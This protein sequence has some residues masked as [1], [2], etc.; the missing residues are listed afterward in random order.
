MTLDGSTPLRLFI[1]FASNSSYVTAAAAEE[2]KLPGIS[3][4]RLRRDALSRPFRATIANVSRVRAG[5]LV[6]NESFF[7]VDPANALS[8]SLSPRGETPLGNGSLSYTAFTNRLVVL[9]I[10]HHRFRVSRGPYRNSRCS[11]CSR[12]TEAR[13]GDLLVKVR[14]SDGFAINGRKTIAI[15]DPLY[16][17]AVLAADLIPGVVALEGTPTNG[18]YRGDGLLLVRRVSVTFGNRTLA[19]SVAL[20]RAETGYV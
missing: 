10:P 4:A 3:E 15:I 19:S 17:G 12:L 18:S 7:V 16:T 2:A 8:V 13:Q 6:F 9:D 11:E 1:D 20:V 5:S 14:A